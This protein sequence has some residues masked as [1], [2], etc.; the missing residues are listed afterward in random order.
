MKRIYRVETIERVRRVVAI[1]AED[2]D[3]A[4]ELASE[5]IGAAHE[6]EMEANPMLRLEVEDVITHDVKD[7]TEEYRDHEVAR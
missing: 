5:A 7:V 2:E 6:K 1:E 3:T 4:V